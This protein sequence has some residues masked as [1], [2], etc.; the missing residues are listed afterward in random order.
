MKSLET[1][2]QKYCQDTVELKNTLEMGFIE[3]GGRLQKIRNER[4]YYPEYEAFWMFCE[5]EVLMSE[6]S[7]SKLIKVYEK[8]TE[9]EIS[10][11][12]VAKI[13]GWT[14]AYQVAQKATSKEDANQ[15]VDNLI[16]HPRMDILK[17]LKERKSGVCTHNWVNFK[18]CTVCSTKEKL[19][20]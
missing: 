10:A 7:C 17:E 14:T 2:N 20:E 5:K 9:W 18:F 8:F 12:K 1:D 4:K 11:E 19:Y 6:S 16:E 3:F 13:G 15:I